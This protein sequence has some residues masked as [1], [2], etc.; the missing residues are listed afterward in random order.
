MLSLTNYHW[1]GRNPIATVSV[2]TIGNAMLNGLQD[3]NRSVNVNDMNAVNEIMEGQ[4]TIIT[5]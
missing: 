3:L 2:D 5:Y 1:H 4:I